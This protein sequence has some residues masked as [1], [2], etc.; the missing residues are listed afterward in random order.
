MKKTISAIMTLVL[1]LLLSIPALA[2]D[3]G[4][5]ETSFTVVADNEGWI[6]PE[7]KDVPIYVIQIKMDLLRDLIGDTNEEQTDLESLYFD[8]TSH[9]EKY[10]DVYVDEF[11]LLEAVKSDDPIIQKTVSLLK[12]NLEKGL[13]VQSAFVVLPY[14][15]SQRKN[16]SSTH[17]I[18]L[19]RGDPNDPDYWKDNSYYWGTYL[20]QEIRYYYI[21]ISVSKPKANIGNRPS[22]WSNILNSVV[23]V[24]VDRLV[25]ATMF[26]VVYSAI[27]DIQTVLDAAVP[28]NYVFDSATEWVKSE[29]VGTLTY[30]EVVLEDI[31]DKISG[32]AYYP[33]GTLEQIQFQT[34]IE[35]KYYAG[36]LN[37]SPNYPVVTSP[38]SDSIYVRSRYYLNYVSLFPILRQHYYYNGYHEYFESV[39]LSSTEF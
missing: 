3:T 11:G 19:T 34:R 27:C 12:A 30:K 4:T 22:L 31:D 1:L 13:D 18:M 26:D 21:S 38:Y 39:D 29:S 14:E 5:L 35:V 6:T 37:G 28:V 16:D 15:E 32:Y 20:G 24:A 36:L 9:Q 10:N 17:S 8:I 25:G 7:S 2:T 23:K 33:W